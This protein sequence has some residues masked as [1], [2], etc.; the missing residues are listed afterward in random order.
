MLETL[1]AKD[2]RV[3]SLVTV[4][5]TTPV[6]IALSAITAHDIGQ[7]PVMKDGECIGSLTESR[8][9][10]E[11]IEDPEIL[12]RPVETVMHAPFPVLD[13]AVAADRV[14]PLLTR[15]NAAVL[16]REGGDIVGI[17]TRYDVVRALTG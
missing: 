15:R 8:L 3:G 9:M 10:A 11:V 5:P 7:L 16:V 4:E 12:D 1:E 2:S 13:G 17:I 14:R 6:R